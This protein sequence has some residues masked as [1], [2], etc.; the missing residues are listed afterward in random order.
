MS[1]NKFEKNIEGSDVEF[2]VIPVVDGTYSVCAVIDHTAMY[3]DRRHAAIPEEL[4]EE[5]LSYYKEK[6]PSMMELKV[7]WAEIS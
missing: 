5:A 7:D 6:T 3:E 4:A 2:D 1:L